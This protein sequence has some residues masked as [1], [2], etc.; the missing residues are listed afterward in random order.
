MTSFDFFPPTRRCACITTLTIVVVVVILALQ[1]RE[2]WGRWSAYVSASDSLRA[3]WKGRPARPPDSAVKASRISLWRTATQHTEFKCWDYR[4]ANGRRLRALTSMRTCEIT[5]TNHCG[6]GEQEVALLRNRQRSPP[7]GFEKHKLV[8]M[9]P[10]E[11][12]PHHHSV[13][14]VGNGQLAANSTSGALVDAA[15]TV[16]RFNDFRL[17]APHRTGRRTD[18]HVMNGNVKGS[19][20]C[21]APINVIIE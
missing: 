10:G 20:A 6:L 13:S 12:I 4:R 2:R 3:L 19:T 21:R 9:R 8:H 1:H 15:D 7:S 16:V 14:V 5:D 11:L 18:V 17:D